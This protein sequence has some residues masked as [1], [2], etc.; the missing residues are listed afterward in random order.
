MDIRTRALE[1]R[2]R[3]TQMTVCIDLGGW[4]DTAVKLETEA[5]AQF[6]RSLNYLVTI[7]DPY[8][9][10]PLK[11]RGG[12]E[13]H[14]WVA[15]FTLCKA[16]EAFQE[17]D[18]KQPQILLI[19]GGI[20]H[21]LMGLRWIFS[22]R[23]RGISSDDRKRLDAY[24]TLFAKLFPDS[25]NVTDLIFVLNSENQRAQQFPD[26]QSRA[27]QATIESLSDRNLL[28]PQ[29]VRFDS[30]QSP[31]TERMAAMILGCMSDRLLER[32]RTAGSRLPPRR[33]LQS[34][35]LLP[36]LGGVEPAGF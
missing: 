21:A 2:S 33:D 15:P 5:L 1:L 23:K 11:K 34:E 13:V 8:T 10:C 31:N 17:G 35:H 18:P 7:L 6:F 3:F 29:T 24:F 16:L 19:N 12:W 30:D 4:P 26:S 32:D 36:D 9:L 22:K 27:V 14:A 28:P 20:I 25:R